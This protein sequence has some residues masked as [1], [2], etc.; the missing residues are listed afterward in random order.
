MA[1]DRDTYDFASMENLKKISC[2][3][4]DDSESVTTHPPDRSLQDDLF[5]SESD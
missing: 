3:D 5:G 1:N 2:E 4:A